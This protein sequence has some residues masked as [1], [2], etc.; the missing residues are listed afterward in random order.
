[1]PA[2]IRTPAP[3]EIER[4]WAEFSGGAPIFAAL[5]EFSAADV[6]AALFEDREAAARG[7]ITW[8]A[9]GDLAEL[10]SVHADPPGGGLGAEMLAYAEGLLRSRGVHR[11]LVATTNDN[12]RALA[13]YQRHGFRLV[14]LRL[15]DMD[16]VRAAKPHVP[17]TGNDGLPLRDLWVLEKRLT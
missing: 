10:V 1:M 2:I 15:G 16:R 9:K 5:G 14:E 11:L 6:E 4:D 12:T 17:L 3:G 13:F 7:L 8:A